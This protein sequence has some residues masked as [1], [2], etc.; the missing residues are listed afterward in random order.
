MVQKRRF[1]LDSSLW[2]TTRRIGSRVLASTSSASVLACGVLAG[3]DKLRQR[4]RL[5]CPRW[6]RQAQPARTRP[7]HRAHPSGARPKRSSAIETCISSRT[8]FTGATG[9]TFDGVAGS[10]LDVISDTQLTVTIP[11]HAEAAPLVTAK[12][13]VAT[14]SNPQTVTLS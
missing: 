1:Q 14:L 12:L 10:L 7:T 13:Q 11:A 6:L 3:F 4:A 8:D 2:Q 9:V 5:R